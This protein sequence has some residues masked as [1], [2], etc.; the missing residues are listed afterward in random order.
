[1]ARFLGANVPIDS[2]F[3][4]YNAFAQLYRTIEGNETLFMSRIR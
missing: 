4:I 3:T 1:M 2:V